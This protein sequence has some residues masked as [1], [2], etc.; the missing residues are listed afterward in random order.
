MRPSAIQD[1]LRFASQTGT[2][3]VIAGDQGV[4][5]SSIVEQ[6]AAAAG[7]DFLLSHPVTWDVTDVKGLPVPDLENNVGRWLPYSDL[8]AAI[9]ATKPTVWLI[10]DLGQA[11][12]AIQAS[13]MQIFLAGRIGEHRISSTIQLI[14]AT[15]RVKDRAGVGMPLE[16]LKGRARLL[17]YDISLDDWSK[18]AA[19][20]GVPP[21]IL[22]FLHFRPDMLHNCQHI[23]DW[24]QSGSTPRGWHRAGLRMKQGV[25]PANEIEVLAGDVGAPIATEFAAYMRVYRELPDLSV[26]ESSP[27]KAPVPT[28]ISARY[29]ITC[30]LASRATKPLLKKHDAYIRRI[31]NGKAEQREFRLLYWRQAVARDTNLGSTAEFQAFA[32]DFQDVTLG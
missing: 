6:Y 26:V 7:M 22:G 18:W 29:A 23:N 9:K 10:D 13:L 25:T 2:P 12:G 17:Q 11:A 14:G 5:K 30:A 20:N 4:G 32:D 19:S 16:P 8:L 3:V 31:K 21:E 1:E 27:D 24:Q 28:D 15:N